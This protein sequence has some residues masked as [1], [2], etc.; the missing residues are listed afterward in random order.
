MLKAKLIKG[1]QGKFVRNVELLHWSAQN[2][3]KLISWL[4]FPPSEAFEAFESQ[5][6]DKL[7]NTK[8]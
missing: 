4:P 2:F 1:L 6:E 7:Y 3:W 5:V 8:S